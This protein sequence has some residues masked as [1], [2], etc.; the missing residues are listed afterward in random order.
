MTSRRVALTAAFVALA[1]G[2]TAACDAGA[3][4]D[5]YDLSD[6]TTYSADGVVD[7]D[8]VPALDDPSVDDEDSTDEEST[9]GEPADEEPIGDGPTDEVFYCADQDGQIVDEEFCD[10]DEDDETYFL[11]HS[12]VYLRGL[13]PGEFLDGG[14]AFPAGDRDA[15]RAFKLPATG[16][17]TNGV[18]KTNVVGRGSV[19]GGVSGTS[20][21]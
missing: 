17:V 13:T 21:G 1:A 18:V 16:K 6:T 10:V 15:R 11:W 5:P 3:D 20:G 4:D 14:D 9:D 19:G 8:A 12:P 2:G 7:S